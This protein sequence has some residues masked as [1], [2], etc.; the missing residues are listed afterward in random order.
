MS[1]RIGLDIDD[2]L[3][4]FMGAY[5]KRFG[6]QKSQT[7]TKHCQNVLR[8]DRKFWTTLKILNRP[9]FNVTLYC[10]KRVNPK[11]YTKY[12]LESNNFPKAPIYQ[13]FYQQGN[14]ADMIKGKVDLFIDDSISNF[15]KLNLSGIP[16]LLF[17][18]EYNKDWGDVARL[19]EFNYNSI[20]ATYNE[21][22]ESGN[23]DNFKNL[24]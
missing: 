11:S 1:L 3:A 16:C 22:I 20:L 2:V 13:M 15:I 7:I 18:K 8:H 5:T 4:D 9:D 19:Y 23:F 10:T 6:I 21:F 14:K 24:L 17:D 12:F